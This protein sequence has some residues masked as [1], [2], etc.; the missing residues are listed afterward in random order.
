MAIAVYFN[1]EGV[2]AAKYDEVIKKLDAAGH[3]TPKG[4]THDR[5]FTFTVRHT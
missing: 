5:T 1:P 3:G 4:R 2:S